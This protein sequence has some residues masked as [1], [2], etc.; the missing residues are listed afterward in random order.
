M[1]KFKNGESF[2]VI[3]SELSLNC[4]PDWLFR[5]TTFSLLWENFW[6][7]KYFKKETKFPGLLV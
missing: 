1:N 2:C 3:Y 6:I 5:L 4:Y 7:F